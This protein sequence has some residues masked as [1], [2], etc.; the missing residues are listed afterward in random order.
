MEI[1]ALDVPGMLVSISHIF[2][3]SNLFIHAARIATIGE[4]AE[5]MFVLST[6]ENQALT[7]QQKTELKD[8]LTNKL[9]VS[10]S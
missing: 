8:I 7:D 2:Q 5:D 9:V 10:S 1:T 6:N 4:K 3:Q